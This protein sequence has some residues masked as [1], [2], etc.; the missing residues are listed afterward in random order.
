MKKILVAGLLF[1]TLAVTAQPTTRSIPELKA[2][3]LQLSRNQKTAALLMLGGGAVLAA[4]GMLIALNSAFYD[5]WDDSATPKGYVAGTIMFYVGG[6]AMLGSIPLF[7]AGAKNKGRAMSASAHLKM[8]PVVN[9][10]E[11]SF[12]KSSYPAISIKFNLK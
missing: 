3:Y 7:I 5:W 6:A 11:R 1:S 4:G 10:Q 8:E 12:V 2:D 9:I